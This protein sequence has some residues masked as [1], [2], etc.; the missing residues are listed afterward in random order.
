MKQGFLARTRTGDVGTFGVLDLDGHKF[1]TGE[2]PDRG[3][4][5]GISSI[6]AGEYECRRTW[7]PRHNRMMYEVLSVPARTG[8]RF[9]VA[10]WTGD[11][12]K[13]YRC[14]VEG[15][16]ALGAAVAEIDGQL[17][18]TDSANSVDLFNTILA[19]ETFRL[20]IVDQYL[21]AGAPPAVA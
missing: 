1:A 5:E 17:G 18:V 12:A 19:G 10:N 7:S 21:E 3:N 13:G 9:D 15:C 11:K 2:L 14:E 6:P 8:V 4:A 16:I 20:R